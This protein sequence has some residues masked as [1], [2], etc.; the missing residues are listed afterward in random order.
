MFNDSDK[1]TNVYEVSTDKYNKLLLD[2]ITKDYEQVNEREV[3]AVNDEA[4]TIADR[5]EIADRVEV[6]RQNL[7]FISIKD[8]KQNFETDTKC[9]LIN[10]AKS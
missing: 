7:A 1:T 4:R 6:M 10:P 5:L 2:N 8:H 9:R 3:T